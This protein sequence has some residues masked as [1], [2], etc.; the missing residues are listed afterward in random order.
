MTSR[1]RSFFWLS[2]FIGVLLC[3]SAVSSP[4]QGLPVAAPQTV[5][6]NAAK[7]NQI[8]A[9]VADAIKDKKLP[10]AVVLV[11][12]KGKIVFRKAYGNRSLVPTV[13][14]MTVDTIF[15]L[16]SLTKPIATATSIMI[17]VEQG[18]LRLN[19]TIGMY[20][21]DIDD[22][23][24]KKVTIQQLLTHTSGYRPD[25]DLGEKWTG[26]DGMLAALKK[27]KLRNPPGTR[28]VYSDI[29]FIVLG[30]IVFRITGRPLNLFAEETFLDPLTAKP[31]F[32]HGD[33]RF[34]DLKNPRKIFVHD[35]VITEGTNNTDY[36][37]A[38]NIRGQSNYLGS[39]FEGDAKTGDKILR[40]QVHDPTA[41]RMGGVAGHAGL[42][43]TADDLARYCQMLLNGGT[44]VGKR[45]MSAQTVARMTAP[46]VVSETGD[47]RGLGWDINT[48]F[49]SNRGELFPLGSFGHTGFTGTSVW[50]DRVSG[51]FVV[52]LSNRVHPDGKGDVTPVRAKV[53]TVVA[54]AIEDT[55]I[56]VYRLAESTYNSA[57]A[58]QVPRFRKFV[59][60]ANRPAA[61]ASA[62]SPVASKMLA[63]PVLN[64]I[65]ILERDKFK[66]LE[67]L[68]IGLVTNHTGR[69][70]AGK[71]TIDILKEVPNVQL[72]SLFAPEHGIRGEL[73]Q[74]KID[75]GKDEKTGLPIYSLYGETRRPKPEQLR[76]LDAIVYDIQDIGARFYTYTATLKNV[77]EEAAKAGKPVFIL[78]RPNP[79]NGNA[80][81]G[82]LADEDKLS[83]IAAHTTPVRYGLTIGELGQ[84]MNAERKIGADLRVIKMEGWTRAMWFDETGQTWVNPSP[85]MRSLTEATLYPGI[86]LLETTNVSV[87]RGTDTPFEIVGAPWLDGRKLAAFLNHR[88]IKGVR[89]VPVRF[90]PTTSVFKDEEC[91]GINIIVTD[92][93]SFNSVRTGFEIAAGLRKLYPSDWQVEKYARLLV[94]AEVLES[95]KRGDT[96]QMIDDAMRTKNEEFARRR[97]LYLLY[98]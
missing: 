80:V 75:D 29:G 72:V 59:A 61:T 23:E 94:N 66:Q 12:H 18:K 39:T 30:D 9:L 22:P 98:K 50:I 15:D 19:D 46:I 35:R 42:F 58:A 27:E 8:D 38:E 67:G 2:L 49:S 17:L 74:A 3:L 65:D 57:I 97:A 68:K 85:N 63:A 71:Q 51:T 78:D 81:E 90:K 11:G 87:G 52:F 26:R 43:S 88:N 89:F 73:D 16:A 1:F 53:A 31:T 20:I 37:P 4:S 13:E 76:D 5:G 6:M 32:V 79:I 21:P 14:K 64:G 96:P 7:L 44:L 95:V 55:P 93:D 91:S 28:F 92:R 69:N 45:V 25:F 33:T 77:L 70:L 56:E 36:A 62:A 40:G 34:V 24:A 10:G 83:F 60:A 84:M 41:F 54:S 48:S 86:G 82:S 47:A